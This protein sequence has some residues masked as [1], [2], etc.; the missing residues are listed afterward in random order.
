MGSTLRL[1][2]LLSLLVA[3]LFF[4]Y[5]L[6]YTEGRPCPPLDDSFIHYQLAKMI[7][8]GHLFAYSAVDGYTK[9]ATSFLFPLLLA[10]FYLAG[11]HG[12]WLLA[13]AFVCGVLALFATAVYSRRLLTLLGASQEA[14]VAA[15]CLVILNGPLVWGFLSGMEIGLFCAFLVAFLYY[16]IAQKSTF[17]WITGVLLCL[18]RPEGVVAAGIVWGTELVLRRRIPRLPLTLPL[19]AGLIPSAIHLIVTGDPRQNSLVGKSYLWKS[20][21][22]SFPWTE[23]G[24]TAAS[25]FSRALHGGLSEQFCGY[26]PVLPVLLG[27]LGLAWGMGAGHG[28]PG[29]SRSL[30]GKPQDGSPGGSPSRFMLEVE[31]TDRQSIQIA[32]VFVAL[33]LV[34][35]VV[36][37]G[38]WHHYRYLMPAGTL[39]A[40]LI[41]LGLHVVQAHAPGGLARGCAILLAASSAVSLPYWAY[42]YGKNAAEI[43]TQD[44]AAASWLTLKGAQFSYPAIFDAGAIPYL[45]GRRC[46]DLLGITTEGVVRWAR[47]GQGS[48]FEKLERLEN[49][50]DLLIVHDHW[51]PG[52]WEVVAG[53]ELA[54][55]V[56]PDPEIVTTGVVRVR[57][58]DGSL[59]GSGG[60][61]VQNSQL[62]GYRLVDE[63]DVADLESEHAHRYRIQLA[64]PDQPPTSLVGRFTVG[65]RTIADGGRGIIGSESFDVDIRS[66]GDF[67]LVI[68]TNQA[69]DRVLE[70]LCN[71]VPAGTVRTPPASAMMEVS[72]AVSLPYPPR[73]P[74][75]LTIVHE[76]DDAPFRE[77]ESYHYW[78]YAP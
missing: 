77:F 55:F 71:G 78:V 4:V 49:R 56:V 69:A 73:G 44:I 62:A 28:S 63:V 54:R 8:E 58:F 39:L 31:R 5:M 61:P 13:P 22:Y 11:F 47:E 3:L 1:Y 15:G 75:R 42:T 59:L 60:L 32:L 30:V 20:E 36:F 57:R 40:V 50:P 68:R 45:S 9:G 23:I 52:L 43:R 29:G 6:S 10:P 35:S 25:R 37:T 21:A 51:L 66:S 14:G 38:W 67:I 72:C 12:L 2:L 33:L 41:G 46:F 26:L 53:E 17:T 48:M 76:R 65:D 34:P 74:T 18:T 70:V 7:A 24:A 64:Y 19:L 27:S 16:A